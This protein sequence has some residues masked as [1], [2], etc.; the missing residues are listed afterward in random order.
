MS[1]LSPNFGDSPEDFYSHRRLAIALQ[2]QAGLSEWEKNFL[3]SVKHQSRPP[4]NKQWSV[5]ARLM[6]K[7]GVTLRSLNEGSCW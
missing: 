7:T 1:K 3:H 5:L 2:Q 6:R 4:S